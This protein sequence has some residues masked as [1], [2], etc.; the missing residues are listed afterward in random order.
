MTNCDSLRHS[1]LTQCEQHDNEM[2]LEIK[3]EG[4]DGERKMAKKV[5]EANS[6]RALVGEQQGGE[7][8][9]KG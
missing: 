4:G 5:S 2:N 7:V 9:I 8:D 6:S 3:R 1:G